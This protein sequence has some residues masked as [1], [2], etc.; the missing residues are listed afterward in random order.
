MSQRTSQSAPVISPAAP[1][2][3][4]G[5]PRW[6]VR[7]VP[8][9]GQ[10]AVTVIG[11]DGDGFHLWETKCRLWGVELAERAA[12]AAVEMARRQPD[13]PRAPFTSGAFLRLL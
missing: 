7:T 1:P 11:Y 5:V 2:Q 4:D 10:D 3:D 13:S 6:C 9:V 8:A 12:R